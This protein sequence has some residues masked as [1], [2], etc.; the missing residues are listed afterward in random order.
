MARWLARWLA[1]L[2]ATCMERKDLTRFAGG[3]YYVSE[4]RVGLAPTIRRDGGPLGS[5][6][7]GCK[8]NAE[9]CRRTARDCGEAVEGGEAREMLLRGSNGS[10]GGSQR[11]GAVPYGWGWVLVGHFWWVWR[12]L[13][14]GRSALK[15]NSPA[16]VEERRGRERA[17][18]HE[19][20]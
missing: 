11:A 12:L 4:T 13:S 18:K 17:N 16:R 1:C 7:V 14:F 3:Y 9:G 19:V 2:V 5:I 15:R 20:R 6:G 8:D 10:N